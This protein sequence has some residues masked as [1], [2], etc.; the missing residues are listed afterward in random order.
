MD[1]TQTRHGD[2][3]GTTPGKP[4]RIGHFRLLGLLGEGGFGMVYEA[5]QT[6]PMVRRVAV[7][8]IKPGMDS[9]A[10]ISRFEA[11][12][13]ALA[14]MDHPCIAKVFDG[15]VTELGLPYFAMELVK[16]MSITQHCDLHMLSIEERIGLF[17]HV[18]DAVQHA[19]S[20]GVIHRDLK[21]S[22]ILVTY[23]GTEH[24]PKVIDFGI[25]KALGQKLSEATIFTKQ[26]QLIGTPEYM[27]PEQAEMGAE[28]IDTRSDV[29]SLGVILYELLTGERP[30]DEQELRDGGKRDIQRI[31]RETEPPRPSTKLSSALRTSR[32][33][34]IA[35]QRRTELKSLSQTLRRDLD[36]VVMKCL[37]KDRS[38]RY[39]TANAL[40][41]ELQRYLDSEPVLA[42][43]PSVRY[44]LGKFVKRNRS[45]VVAALLCLALLVGGLAGT[46]YGFIEARRQGV[47][48]KAAAVAETEQRELAEKRASELELVADFQSEQLGAIDA[49]AMGDQIRESI[50]AAA[51]EGVRGSLGESLSEVNFTNIALGTLRANVIERTI[52]AIDRQFSDQPVVQAMLLQSAADTARDLGLYDLATGPQM[53]ALEIRRR[54]LGNDD[55]ATLTSMNNTGYLL[56]TQGK[57]A[58]AEPYWRE[59]LDGYKRTRA[60]DDS[61]TLTLVSNMGFLL[62]AQG[63]NAEAEACYR[64]ALD[65]YRRTLGNDDRKTLTLVNNMASLLQSQSKYEEAEKYYA[66]SLSGSRRVLGNDHPETLA[67]MNNMSTLYR[68]I[69]KYDEAE[70]LARE[71]LAGARR[72]LG[73]DHPNTLA[74]ANNLGYLLRMQERYD[75]AEPLIRQALDGYLKLFGSDHPSSLA[76]R[77][78]YALLLQGQGRLEEAREMLSQGLADRRRVMGDDHPETLRSISANAVILIK[79]G[80]FGEAEKLALEGERRHAAVYGPAHSETIAVTER[81]VSLY[82]AWDE[83]E[84]G[85]GHAEQAERW[86]AKLT[87]RKSTGG[88]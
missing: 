31:I 48:A 64:E 50:I 12:R 55:N 35:S 8:V 66:E 78:S 69:R 14:V 26:G 42:G 7:K 36:W 51:P 56:Q 37:E 25:A 57:Y 19:H 28:D 74:A 76:V 15:G 22:N 13:Q 2:R 80:R 59:A 44:K 10:V 5:E 45:G 34:M 72:V 39:E 30:F 3:D 11:E 9:K 53:R 70:K 67:T 73:D 87:E 4:E 62:R 60:A 85:Q 84:P 21:P 88:G 82:E 32:A 83:S 77:G 68:S 6:E 71:S 23:Q 81:I 24:T 65:G 58:E 29:Y 61:S 40:A 47:R 49:E 43:P 86:R 17:I 41:V 27:S 18:C 79:L 1:A 20:K 63:K 75:E 54:E 52:E 16:G 46:S 38:R 33:A